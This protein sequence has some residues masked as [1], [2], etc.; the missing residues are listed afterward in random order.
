MRGKPRICGSSK[1]AR[2]SE[3]VCVRVS[4]HRGLRVGSEDCGIRVEM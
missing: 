3:R 1:E 4:V 2:D